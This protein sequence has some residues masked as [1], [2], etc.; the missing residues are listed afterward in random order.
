MATNESEIL[1]QINSL[2][3]E[4]DVLRIK[5]GANMEKPP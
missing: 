1:E 3:S 2:R 5:K 4:I